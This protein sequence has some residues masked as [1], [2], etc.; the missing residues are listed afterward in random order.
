MTGDYYNTKKSVKEYIS[1]AEGVNGGN[2][3]KKLNAFLPKNA[4][5][6]EIGSGP[7]TDWKILNKDYKVVGS[8]NSKEFLNHLNVNHVRGKFIELD[9]TTLDI[10]AKFD[11]MFSNKVLHHLTNE[12]LDKS[13]EN[14]C[15][16]LNSK[17]I[18]CHSFWN[19]KGSEIFKGLFVN[20]HT[21]ET[22]KKFFDAKFDILLLEAYQEFEAS[23]SLVIIARK[24]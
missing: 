23:D 1:L 6:L 17:G 12:E 15:K 13:I 16:I 24:K 14:S 19:G 8:D 3:I 4:S 11:G 20:Y 2:L 7:G 18:V 5:V 10:E 9:A 21:K 22:L